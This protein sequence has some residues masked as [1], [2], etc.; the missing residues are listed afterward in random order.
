MNRLLPLFG[1]FACLTIG[2]AACNGTVMSDGFPD[3]D[4]APDDDGQGGSGAAGGAGGAG[5]APTVSSSSTGMNPPPPSPAISMLYS[6]LEDQ[7][8]SSSSGPATG[9]TGNTSGGGT[10]VATVSSGSTIDPDT[11]VIFLG[12]E[13]QVCEDP[14]ASD[15]NT[16]SWRV[17][18]HLP[19]THQAVGT[20]SLDGLGNWSETISCGSGGGGT[21]WEG[22]IQITAIDQD[23][24][25]FTLAGTN[26]FFDFQG[27]ADGEYTAPRCF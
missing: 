1:L 20:Y 23:E 19:T 18:L 21:Y 4:G 3:D 14:Y 6:E 12:S 24:I 11:L 8:S 25:S 2:A 7:T 17:S 22:T 15:C 26:P 16:P 9:S 27:N 13:L 10:T 5:G